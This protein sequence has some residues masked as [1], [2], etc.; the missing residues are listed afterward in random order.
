MRT[1]LRRGAIWILVLAFIAVASIATCQEMKSVGS[2]P[3]LDQLKLGLIAMEEGAFES[4][5]GYY[6]R[7]LEHANTRELRF[8]AYVGMGSAE[9]A[10]DRLEDARASFARALEIKPD[11]PE[12]LFAAGMVAREMDDYGAAAEFFAQAA[13]RDPGFGEA[14]TQLGVVYA[15]EERHEEAASACWKAVSINPKDVEA[16]LCLGVARYQLGR[17]ADAALAF[18]TVIE[19]DPRNSRGRYSLGLCKLYLDDTKGAIDEYTEL[20]DLDPE[21]ASDLHERIFATP[22]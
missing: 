20:N 7:A 2:S 13:V 10:L 4:A 9:A 16:L 15:I 22:Q 14:L 12:A 18:E 17:Y 21:L 3:S 6:N 8:Q 11:N 5:L 1:S 19:V